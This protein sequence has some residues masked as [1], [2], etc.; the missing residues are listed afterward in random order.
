MS[1]AIDAVEEFGILGE[2]GGPDC[3]LGEAFSVFV[4]SGQLSCVH[5]CF[6]ISKLQISQKLSTEFLPPKRIS[7]FRWGSATSVCPKR[8]AGIDDDS[9]TNRLT[10]ELSEKNTVKILT[11]TYITQC[12]ILRIL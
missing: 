2:D 7:S 5:V 3:G 9:G 4:N 1:S 8:G 6:I 11:H 10:V 12:F